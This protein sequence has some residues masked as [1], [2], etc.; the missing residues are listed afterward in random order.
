MGDKRIAV[1]ASD[2]VA[3][4]TGFTNEEVALAV[5]LRESGWTRQAIV[6][7]VGI[8]LRDVAAAQFTS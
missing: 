6:E 2:S 4:L 7:T 5:A 8:D 1:R 3:P